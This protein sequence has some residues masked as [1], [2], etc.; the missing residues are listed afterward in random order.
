[1]GGM[2]RLMRKFV[3]HTEARLVCM[4]WGDGPTCQALPHA[5]ISTGPPFK[6]HSQTPQ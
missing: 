5:G 1:M 2:R 4:G 6:V 3:G